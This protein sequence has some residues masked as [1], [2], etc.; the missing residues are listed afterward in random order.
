MRRRPEHRSSRRTLARLARTPLFFFAGERRRDVIGVLG[1]PNV[2]LHA[3][4]YVAERFDGD[5]ERASE[6][7]E[8][9]AARLLG[10]ASPGRLPAGE[11]LALRRW[12][13]LV[14]VLPGVARWSAAERRQ[15][16]EVVRLKGSRRESD[17]VRA[18]DRHAKL[19]VAIR[20]LARE[21]PRV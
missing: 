2:G 16:G 10:I 13:P 21:E 14:F 20:A 12:G 7:C 11:R 4:R 17:F 1:L 6:V 19:R 8:A 18:F 5:A 15:L 9:E 3:F